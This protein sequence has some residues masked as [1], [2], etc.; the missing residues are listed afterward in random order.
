[1]RSL[2]NLALLVVP[3]AATSSVMFSAGRGS[4]ITSEPLV[5]TV[6]KTIHLNG[7]LD[8]D[9]LS[10]I[11]TVQESDDACSSSAVTI[12]GNDLPDGG[13]GQFTLVD[14]ISATGRWK[15]LCTG[16]EQYLTMA[17]DAIPGRNLEG[18]EFIV[19]FRQ[20]APVE[21]V[22]IAGA[23]RFVD[24]EEEDFGELKAFGM[25]REEVELGLADNLEELGM[26]SGMVAELEDGIRLKTGILEA[27][28]RLETLEGKVEDVPEDC[29]GVLCFLK[30]ILGR[31]TGL[32]PPRQRRWPHK[33]HCGNGTGNHTH[34]NHT[35]PH[36]PWWRHPHEN[37]TH[38][39][40]TIPHPPWWR[41][42]HGNHT[43][44][45]YTHGNHTFPHLPWKRPHH[46]PPF[47]CRPQHHP[48]KPPHGKPPHRKPPHEKPSPSAP[49]RLRPPH[50]GPPFDGPPRLRSPFDRPS[51]Q[52]ELD[53]QQISSLEIDPARV[54][55]D[56][57]LPQSPLDLYRSAQPLLQLGVLVSIIA[58]LVVILHARCCAGRKRMTWEE[59]R[60]ARRECVRA[61]WAAMRR[62]WI[63]F[64]DALRPEDEYGYR[65]EE[66]RAEK[67]AILAGY[68]EG[69]LD[70]KN[71]S[72][73]EGPT[74]VVLD[75]KERD[76]E[77]QEE[78]GIMAMSMSQELA[79]FQDAVRMVSEIVDRM[80]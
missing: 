8:V 70:E 46:R 61:R 45:N 30:G 76:T 60:E 57:T 22:D 25:T 72:A 14:D 73:Y 52:Q 5:T 43:H 68:G 36:P 41:H 2:P 67:T 9:F 44:G 35:F 3:V 4:F 59:R 79:S 33:G 78:E 80:G 65:E 16:E 49:P 38:E 50:D 64:L 26:L 7:I 75:E 62:H 10:L 24:E 34:G 77:E 23:G 29:Y 54:Q 13:R 58:A 51:K 18:V 15:T 12:G 37:H 69:P 19:R 32:G 1:M 53:Q 21:V 28:L 17:I 55:G 31:I 47:F 27:M 39:N 42:P 11:F 71:E 63:S 48:G 66:G 74:E 56:Q 40:H 20:I 6:S